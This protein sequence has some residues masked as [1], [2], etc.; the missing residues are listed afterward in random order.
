MKTFKEENDDLVNSFINRTFK[1]GWS[2]GLPNFEK[3]ELEIGTKCDL[4]CKYCYFNRH[5]EKLYPSAIQNPKTVYANL[6]ILLDWMVENGYHPEIDFFSGEPFAQELGFDGIKLI[7][8]KY[9]SEEKKPRVIVPTNYTFLLSEEKTKRVEDLINYGKEVGI[10][11]ILSASM[12]GKY[13]EQN[14]PF[15]TG[16]ETRNN[17]YYDKCFKF[18]KKWGF[19]FHPMVYSELIEN[20]KENF[21]WFQRNFEKYGIHF[22]NIYLLEVRNPEWNRKQMRELMNFIDFLV[23][24]S[25]E[26]PCKKDGNNLIDLILQKRGYNILANAFSSTGRGLGC[27][28]QATLMV[29]LGDLA[30]VPCHRTSHAPFVTGKFKVKNGKIAGIESNNPELMIG[31][32]SFQSNNSP[33]CETCPIKHL[34]SK[35]C[36][37]SQFETTGDLFSPIPTVCQMEHAK[38]YSLVAS[39]KK[40]GVYGKI[41][42]RLENDKKAS[43]DT[44]EEITK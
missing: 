10:D 27:S 40:I 13:C 20:W 44:L 33:I 3:I 12:D 21:L 22:F 18:G 41:Y 29:R 32:F 14:R 30:I 23:N 37:G 26:V 15:A 31:E 19:G 38:I 42:E 11:V 28:I 9:K 34:C 1:K 7:L 36:L 35:G 17:E 8:D 2:E 5:G 43:L 16:E 24:W 6:E 4:K 25:Y 39:L